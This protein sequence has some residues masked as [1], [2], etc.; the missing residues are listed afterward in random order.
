MLR[1]GERGSGRCVFRIRTVKVCLLE[2]LK[3]F[4]ALLVSIDHRGAFYTWNDTAWT[5]SSDTEADNLKCSKF[6]VQ[7]KIKEPCSQIGARHAWQI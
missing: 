4:N 6:Q 1:G 5:Y 2:T 3:P 7:N